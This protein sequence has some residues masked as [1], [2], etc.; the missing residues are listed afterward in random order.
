MS[1]LQYVTNQ[2]KRI[3]ASG[4]EGFE[5]LVALLL[6]RLTGQRFF[7]AQAGSQSGRDM[8]TGGFD[9][10]SIAVEAKRFRTSKGFRPRD[11]LG[12][13]LELPD[14]LDLWVIVSTSRVPDQVISA[15]LPKAAERGIAVEVLDAPADRPG[16]LVVLCAAH[17]D[18]I[19]R[20][21][22]RRINRDAFTQAL[23]AIQSRSD[24][25]SALSRL[26]E[27]FTAGYIGY[28][29][30]RKVSQAYLSTAFES[31]DR[32]SAELGQPVN[33]LE[34]EGRHVVER[35]SVLEALSSWWN[36]GEKAS[37]PF[38]L[39][40]EEGMG[41]TWALASWLAGQMD[42]DTLP[43]VLFLPAPAVDTPQILELI[44]GALVRCTGI[45]DLQF[46]SRRAKTFA[47]RPLEAGP[48]FL[49]V[50]DGLNEHPQ[51]AW[52]SLLDSFKVD[53]WAKQVA[54]IITCRPAYWSEALSLA[55]GQDFQS[56]T[57]EPYDDKE[58]ESAIEKADLR[59]IEFPSTL[60]PLLRRPRYFNLTAKHHIAL[61]VSGDI[62]VDRLLY[63]DWKDRISRKR[64][65]PVSDQDFRSLLV[66]LAENFR[67]KALS[68]REV[69]DLLPPGDARLAGLYEILTGGILVQDSSGRYRVEPR[70]LEQ[71]FGLLLAQQVLAVAGLGDIAMRE[72]L[73][74]FLEPLSDMDRKVGIYR[75]AVTCAILEPEFPEQAKFILFEQW[76]GNHNLSR[77]DF[78][79]FIAYLP[80]S[81]DSYLQLVEH[82]WGS[83]RHPRIERLLVQAFFRWR[84]N[85][86]VG[87]SLIKACERWLSFVHPFGFTFAGGRDDSEKER[88]RKAIESRVGQP[89]A[90][91]QR[92]RVLDELEVIEEADKLRLSYPALL[93][94]SFHPVIPFIP[95]LRHWALS[96]SVMGYPEEIASV[97]WILRWSGEELWAELSAAVSPLLEGDIV[98]QRAAWRL[99]W[100]C[101][102]EEAIRIL[103]QLPKDLFPSTFYDEAYAEDPCKLSWR[104]E[105]CTLCAARQDL[106]DLIVA[107][108]L[109]PYANDP[110]FHI[111]VDVSA[112][113]QGALSGIRQEEVF[114]GRMMTEDDLNFE[115]MEP[116]LAA[117]APGLLANFYRAL[118]RELTH[119]STGDQQILIDYLDVMSILLEHDEQGI[120]MELWREACRPEYWDDDAR[121]RESDLFLVLLCQLDAKS[122]LVAFIERPPEAFDDQRFGRCVKK[123]N[124]E[125]IKS[126][127]ESIEPSSTHG[128]VRKLIFLLYQSA[129]S[130]LRFLGAERLVS[131]LDYGDNDVRQ[132]AELLIFACG[133]NAVWDLVIE[134]EKI[135]PSEMVTILSSWSG[136][137]GPQESS[138]PYE[139]LARTVD[140]G[141]L[142]YIVCRRSDDLEEYGRDLNLA[143]QRVARGRNYE[144]HSELQG[145]FCRQ[146]LEDL[147]KQNRGMVEDWARLAVTQ[148]RSQRPGILIMSGHMMFEALCEVLVEESPVLGDELFHALLACRQR[149][150]TVE[151][152][153][154]VDVLAT[155]LFRLPQ[156]GIADALLQEWVRG[157]KTDKELFELA[158]AAS[159][160]RKDLRLHEII[161]VRFESPAPVEKASALMLSGF[162]IC[163]TG[164]SIFLDKVEFHRESWLQIVKDRALQ[165]RNRDRWAQTWFKRFV[166]SP[167]V[168]EAFGCFRLFLRCVDRRYFIWRNEQMENAGLDS[169]RKQYLA[170]Q[171]DRILKAIQKNEGDREKLLVG[172][173]IGVGNVYPWLQR[174]LG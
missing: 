115:Q 42:A 168:E 104:R 173:G 99:V 82:F 174:Y 72:A 113:L 6:E 77:E 3:K 60:D 31:T 135:T 62:T 40:G 48:S 49:I 28:A 18:L 118:V 33:V 34:Y 142:S 126:L 102:R 116:T 73:A 114:S 32:S 1:D 165:E 13:L 158:L 143:V 141:S 106:S 29:Q 131:L 87:A 162:S 92:I 80:A 159:F 78:E 85:S 122:Q 8:S 148:N 53:P 133:S 163:G 24:F 2:L 154:R 66:Q 153:I 146:T 145:G 9:G 167:S 38:V 151:S 54:A 26:R 70:R 140:L 55:F 74:S 39:L 63:E 97:S 117:L 45:R 23:A 7:L 30:A 150:S 44:S 110:D 61:E 17:P 95:A 67:L 103:R 94:A 111:D 59:E 157:C 127:V 43:V 15:L 76:I 64:G 20:F 84:A 132:I 109:A 41:K 88:V 170:V 128:L 89:I 149:V 129:E 164:P 136:V 138:L 161:Q 37:V 147:Y 25:H 5:G 166:K 169:T 123:L 121:N 96:R 69:Y 27:R 56:C 47:K 46:W 51:F 68:K 19:I 91:G 57:V 11:L 107:L 137:K 105:D 36:R 120:I 83:R 90:A 81:V 52:R 101:G 50:L 119:R 79:S 108:K 100:A 112:R 156:D 172:E 65:I 152:D 10:T 93:L 144:L 35:H 98:M 71:G 16:D 86:G 75:S 160:T 171:H 4:P 21:L 14:W 125:E 124:D 130:L 134:R 139:K 155:M 12:E 58:L 22:D